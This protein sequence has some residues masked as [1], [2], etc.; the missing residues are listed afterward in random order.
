MAGIIPENP[1]INQFSSLPSEELFSYDLW[2]LVDDHRYGDAEQV[3]EAMTSRAPVMINHMKE[4]RLLLPVGQPW[5]NLTPQLESLYSFIR[6]APAGVFNLIE[7]QKN[8]EISTSDEEFNDQVP[9][10][11]Y[12]PDAAAQIMALELIAEIEELN[13]AAAEVPEEPQ[14]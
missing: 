14:I 2:E 12:A 7:E 9:E 4:G 13:E 8:Q 5:A 3:L 11:S 10:P 6:N 1:Q